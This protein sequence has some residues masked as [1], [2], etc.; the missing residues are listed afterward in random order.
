[1][2]QRIWP[3]SQRSS[4]V[5]DFFFLSPLIS[6]WEVPPL[7]KQAN[8]VRCKEILGTLAAPRTPAQREPHSESAFQ[9]VTRGRAQVDFCPMTSRLEG[10]LF[11][12]KEE[13]RGG[14]GGKGR[15]GL[16]DAQPGL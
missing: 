14:Q 16:E 15:A 6:K 3:H 11:L 10:I 1:M 4:S 8:P 5:L 12:D 9:W 7:T 2:F 13:R